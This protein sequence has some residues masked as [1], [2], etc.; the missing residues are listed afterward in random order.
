MWF[1]GV[2]TAAGN[3]ARYMRQGEIVMVPG[4]SLL[5]SARPSARFP[6][7]R[8]EVLPNRDSLVY[9]DLYGISKVL[10]L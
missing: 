8:F 7:M 9:R 1:I 3:A 6:T 4:P 10:H 5:R 2:M